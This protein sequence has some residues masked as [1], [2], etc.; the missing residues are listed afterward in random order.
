MLL[1]AKSRAVCCTSF[2]VSVSSKS[3]RGVL[4]ALGEGRIEVGGGCI[5]FGWI[6][7]QTP[8]NHGVERF[9]DGLR[10]PLRGR[11]GHDRDVAQQ[12]RRRVRAVEGRTT[13]EGEVE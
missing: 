2:C 13:R 10:R 3:T 11:L 4:H 8:K 6:F 1:P 9:G 7:L 5:T 12:H